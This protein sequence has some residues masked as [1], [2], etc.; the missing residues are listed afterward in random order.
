MQKGITIQKSTENDMMGIM[1]LLR[2][3]RY[4]NAS[5]SM[6]K[7]AIKDA[8]KDG[9]SI[10]A[11]NETGEI[12]GHN[13]LFETHDGEVFNSLSVIK[14]GYQLTLS[15]MTAELLRLR[16]NEPKYEE[17]IPSQGVCGK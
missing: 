17:Y 9:K 13:V 2:S 15:E 11:K 4:S 3:T 16:R 1:V 6:I 7:D 10:V 5:I 14:P 12:I 8:I